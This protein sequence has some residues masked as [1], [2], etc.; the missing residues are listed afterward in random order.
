MSEIRIVSMKLPIEQ[1]K[2]AIQIV[3]SAHD[4]LLAL[5][6]ERAALGTV[7]AVRERAGEDGVRRRAVALDA[8]EEHWAGI[9]A[10][11][12]AAVEEQARAAVEAIDK[13]VTPS[14]ADI[15]GE[16]AADFALIP[17]LYCVL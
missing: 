7:E 3:R 12:Q 9:V 2:N 1:I 15:L 14:G 13:Q 5:E 8:I 6:R 10:D 17:L 11:A 4:K 16:N